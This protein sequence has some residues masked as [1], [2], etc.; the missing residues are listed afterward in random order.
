MEKGRSA[1]VEKNAMRVF[2][3][4]EGDEGSW[5]TIQPY[6]KLRSLGDSVLISDKVVLQSSVDLQPLHLSEESL[7]N[8]PNLREVVWN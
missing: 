2:M 8:K 1:H 3:S 5:F 7:P 6:Y 4:E